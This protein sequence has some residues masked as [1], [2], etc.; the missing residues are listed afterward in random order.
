MFHAVTQDTTDTFL[1]S[2][3]G[4]RATN[5]ITSSFIVASVKQ[6]QKSGASAKPYDLHISVACVSLPLL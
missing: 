1:V 6:V 3:P 4:N 5:I 2:L